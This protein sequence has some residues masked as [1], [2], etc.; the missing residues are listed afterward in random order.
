M[1]FALLISRVNTKAERIRHD[2]VNV[3]INGTRSCEEHVR[4]E[5]GSSASVPPLLLFSTGALPPL[6]LEQL[7]Y[8]EPEILLSS[9]KI[10]S[11]L[12]FFFFFL[13]PANGTI[14]TTVSL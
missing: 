13:H 11:L 7:N 5:T 4:P 6:R 12:S 3:Q 9:T 8:P 1:L 14:L 2:D 10:V